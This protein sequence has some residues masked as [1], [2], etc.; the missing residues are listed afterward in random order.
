MPAHI[1]QQIVYV[2]NTKSARLPMPL[3]LV[4]LRLGVGTHVCVEEGARPLARALALHVERAVLPV[5]FHSA[6]AAS[7][8]SP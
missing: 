4:R 3:R 7:A 5:L 6:K 1:N 8:P 2:C